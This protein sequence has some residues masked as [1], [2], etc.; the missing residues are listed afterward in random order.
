MAITKRNI[1][2]K[3]KTSHSSYRFVFLFIR[4]QFVVK[5]GFTDI[6]KKAADHADERGFKKPRIKNKN[7]YL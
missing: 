6:D 3:I 4:V 1:Y 2:I 7:K 5:A